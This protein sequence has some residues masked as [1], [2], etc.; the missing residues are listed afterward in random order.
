MDQ[1]LDFINYF[2]LRGI[3]DTHFL[4]ISGL[5]AFHSSTFCLSLFL[6]TFMAILFFKM[7]HKFSKNERLRDQG[8]HDNI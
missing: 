5:I 8:G 1:T 3:V 7:F 2:I 4:Q 6:A